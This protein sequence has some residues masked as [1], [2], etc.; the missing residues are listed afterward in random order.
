[1]CVFIHN[2]A[3]TRKCVHVGSAYALYVDTVATNKHFLCN[4]YKQENVLQCNNEQNFLIWFSIQFTFLRV[5]LYKG[6]ATL[7]KM[8][9]ATWQLMLE[10]EQSKKVSIWR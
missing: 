9:I 6:K 3:S 10:A 7:E 2:C 5:Q 4:N 8:I 1:M